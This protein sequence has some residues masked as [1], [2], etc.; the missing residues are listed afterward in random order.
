MQAAVRG[1]TGYM[2][3]ADQE[4]FLKAHREGK[5]VRPEDSGYVI[6]SLALNASKTLSGQFVSWDSQECADFRRK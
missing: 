1:A 2:A 4:R 5:L 3:S 6:A